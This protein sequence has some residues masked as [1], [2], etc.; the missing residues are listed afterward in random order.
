M[1]SYWLEAAAEID[2]R[3]QL[4]D[5]GWPSR[6][7]EVPGSDFASYRWGDTVDPIT[8][9]LTDR[10]YVARELIPYGTPPSADLLNALDRQMQEGILDPAALTPVARLMGVGD[11]VLRGDLAYERYNLARPRQVY[12]LLEEAPGLGPVIGFGG[13]EPNVP[14]PRLP[15]ED[16]IELGADPDLPDPPKV[17][18]FPVSGD[19]SIVRPS[20]SRPRSSSRERPTASSPPPPPGVIDGDELIRYSAS[21]AAEGGGGDEA[22]V[23]AAGDDAPLVITDSNRKAR[24]ALGRGPRDR[25]PHRDRRPRSPWSTTRAT[26]GSPSSRGPA[27]T[28]RPWPCSRGGVSARATSYGNSISYTPENRAANALD[29]DPRTAW[30]VGAFGPAEGERIEVTY[31]EP[32]TT[33]SLRLLQAN[34]GVQNRW[35]TEVRAPLRR[36]R[37]R[38]TSTCPRP[39]GPGEG[40]TLTF[41]EQTFSTLDVEIATTDP[42]RRDTYDGLSSVGLADLRLG[43]GD[44]RLDES[45][46]LPTDV[47][48]ALGPD[49][50]DHPLV[51]VLTR[52]RTRPTAALR[53]DEETALVRGRDPARGPGVRAQPAPAGSPPPSPTPTS[54]GSSGARDRTRAGSSRRP[55]AG[56]PATSPPAPR[57]PSTA[58]RPPTGAP[59]S[60]ARTPS[61]PRYRLARAAD[62]RPH[63]PRGRGRRSPQRARPS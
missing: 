32:R 63:G 6:I 42:G 20:P 45:V 26:T 9:G 3:G 41:P 62:H 56:S 51:L 5:G 12:A 57:P 36:R 19:P 15:L 24:P 30:S 11:V 16:E 21:F 48:D 43:D 61:G 53:T 58:T 1:P 25:G 37:S 55:P 18:L 44:V 47:L 8:P 17:G 49:S 4:P 14:D 35:I 39:P 59:A 7:L 2:A 27:P 23:E 28:P 38:S 34:N 54:T 40:E 60:S 46:R 10:P 22:L 31:D 13:T 50:T 52:R 33:D 29:D